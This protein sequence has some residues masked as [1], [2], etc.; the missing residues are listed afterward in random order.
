[1]GRGFDFREYNSMFVDF[2]GYLNE[3]PRGDRLEI[4]DRYVE[5]FDSL[6]EPQQQEIAD[7]Y[8]RSRGGDRF[9]IRMVRTDIRGRG[10][11]SEYNIRDLASRAYSAGISLPDP[12]QFRNR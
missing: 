3:L 12:N 10:Y 4:N 9:T 2:Q 6:S 8:S 5:W 1:M 7:Q 11:R